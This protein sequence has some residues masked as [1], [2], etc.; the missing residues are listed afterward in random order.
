MTPELVTTL[1]SRVAAL[2]VLD[3]DQATAAWFLDIDGVLNVIGAPRVPLA[4][5][6][7]G[8][9][10]YARTEVAAFE[11]LAWPVCFAPALIGMLNELHARNIVSFRWLTTWTHDAPKIFAPAIGLDVGRWIAS[12]DFGDESQGRWWKLDVMVDVLKEAGDLV[13]WTDDEI[14]EYHH[15]RRIVDFLHPEQAL[16]IC[17]DKRKGLSPEQFD[18]ILSALERRM[19]R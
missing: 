4:A 16:V 10:H 1:Q 12:D 2:P 19:A 17:P 14:N 8:W 9:G 18:L 6:S 11:G 13:I 7:F 15:A 5:P 3:A